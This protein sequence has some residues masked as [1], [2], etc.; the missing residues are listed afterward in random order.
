MSDDRLLEL[1]AAF[2]TPLYIFDEAVL[3]A[4]VDALRRALPDVVDLCYAVKANTFIVP[5]LAGS[6]ERFEVC[7]PGELAICEAVGAPAS[8][9]VISGVYKDA[10]TVEHALAGPAMPAALTV[11]SSSQLELIADAAAAAGVRAPVLL[12]LTSGN[13]FG[14]DRSEILRAVDRFAEDERVELLGIQFFSGTQKTS[15]RRIGRE[16]DRLDR[17]V[18]ELVDE[19][20]WAPGELEYGPGLPVSYFEADRFDETALLAELGDMLRGMAFGGRI[21]LEIGRSIAASCGTYLTSVVDTKVNASQ[22]YA[23]VDGGMH[24][25]VYYGHSMAMRQPP[26][27]LLG[28]AGSSGAEQAQ[29]WNICG[30]LCTI[31]DILA[32]QLPVEGLDVGRVLAFETAG[33]YCVTEGMSLFLSRDLPAVVLLGVDGAPRLARER[34]RTDVL[35]APGGLAS[36]LERHQ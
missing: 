31:N 25:L 10:A 5:G 11:E 8:D 4:R 6:V 23:I 20:G 18:A 19:H 34:M 24:Q 3:A 14:L 15:L 33:A 12:R 35:N 36:E 1:A 7:S 21:T 28:A 27:R 26:V 32:K 9:M 30:A 2:G 13:Q 22:R 17:L 29:P 16:L